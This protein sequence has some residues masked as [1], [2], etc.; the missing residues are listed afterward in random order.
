M[1]RGLALL[2]YI[3]SPSRSEYLCA[4]RQELRGLV[5]YIDAS[6]SARG[7]RGAKHAKLGAAVAGALAARSEAPQLSLATSRECANSGGQTDPTHRSTRLCSQTIEL[8]YF[9]AHSHGAPVL[10]HGLQVKASNTYTIEGK[11]SS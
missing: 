3:P 11:T 2:A 6:S 7:S 8:R 1:R 10:Y 9:L 5:E 4:T